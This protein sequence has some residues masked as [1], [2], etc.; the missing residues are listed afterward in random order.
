MKLLADLRRALGRPVSTEPAEGEPFD[1]AAAFAARDA[2]MERRLRHPMAKGGIALLIL[3]VVLLVWASL[4]RV[5]GAVLAQGVIKVEDNS[6][7]LSR[8]ESGVVRDILVREGQKVAQGQLLIRFDDTQSEASVDIF[9][10]AVD[11][12]HAQI[13]RFQ[14]EAANASSV[15]FPQDLVARAAGDPNVAALLDG[16]RALFETRMTLYRSQAMVL[17]SQAQQLDT[18][19][20][21]LQ[22]QADAIEDQGKLIR[23]ELQGVRELARQGYA[24]NSRLLALE[25]STVQVRGQKGSAMSDIARAR[26]SIGQIRLQIAQLD[27][28]HQTEVAD[29]IRA[30]QEKLAEA[31][32]KLRSAKM[33]LQQTE[34]RAPVAGYVFNLTQ[35][36]RGGIAGAGQPLLQIVP[37]NTKLV[38]AAEVSPRDVSDVR[39]DMPARVTLVGFNPRL[40]SPVDGKVTLVSADARTNEKTGQS[41]FLV[42]ITVPAEQIAKAGPNVRLVPG[43]QASVAIVTGERTIIDYLLEPFTDSMRTALRER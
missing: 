27:D 11:S 32:P 31:D 28:K 24:P 41:H 37:S 18:Q 19:V 3:I 16:Q 17:R 21:G 35:F 22:I 6:K 4:F 13:A 23:E 12:A 42:E 30:A 2:E 9:Q 29:G 5:S 7:T 40:V 8:L 39:R 38:V 10:S 1:P 34:I 36:T 33:M 15:T 25:R 14:A 43:M 26:Q 20:A